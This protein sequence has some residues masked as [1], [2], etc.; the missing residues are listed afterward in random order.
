MKLGLFADPHYCLSEVLCKTRR[1]SLSLDKISEAV[2][3]FAREKCDLCLCLGDLTDKGE[4]KEEATGCLLRAVEEIKK[5][6]VLFRAI[7]GNHDCCRFTPEEFALLTGIPTCLNFLDINGFRFI[8]LDAN[9]RSDL[10]HF[11][12]GDFDWKDSNLPPDQL[13]FLA[14]AIDFSLLPCVCVVHEVLDPLVRPDHVIK[15]AGEARR[16][17]E[18]SGKVKLILQGHYH[19]GADHTV[20][21]IRYLTLPAMCEGTENRYKVLEI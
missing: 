21:G 17:I 19:K 16:I 10:V 12:A 9:Y 3:V 8:F 18:E 4:S 15:N 14:A 7:M 13:S 6:G 1:P 20:N 11:S 5:S 2:G